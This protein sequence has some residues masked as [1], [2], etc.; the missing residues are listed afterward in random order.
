VAQA[1]RLL[2][3]SKC[4]LGLVLRPRK[5]RGRLAVSS[6]RPSAGTRRAVGTRVAVRVQAKR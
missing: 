1:R 6:Q 4:R 2:A 3:R 5:A